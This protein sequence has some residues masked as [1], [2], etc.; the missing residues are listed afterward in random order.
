MNAPPVE[1]LRRLERFQLDSPEAALPFSTRL[2][3][4][5]NWPLPYTHRV[6]AEYKRFAFLAV[7]AGHP[8]SPSEDVDQAWHLHLTYSENYWKVFCPEIL[9]QPLHHQPT[10]GGETERDKFEDWYARTLASYEAFFGASPPADIWPSPAARRMESHDFVRV[11]RK[12]SWVI[13]KPRLQLNPKFAAWFGLGALVLAGS[14]AMLAQ[15]ANPF[16]WRGS[17]FLKFYILLFIASFAVG[18]VLRR[19]LRTP[20]ATEPLA[21]PDLDGY[22]TA[23]LNGGKLL[24]VNT[25]V[26]TLANQKAIKPDAGNR[27]L[28]SLAPKPSFEHALERGVYSAADTPYGKTIAEVRNAV[29]PIVAG[30]AEDLKAQGLVVSDTAARRAILVPLGIA[31]AAIAVG[32]VKIIIGIGRD[33]PVGILTALCIVSLFASLIAFARRPLRSRKGDAVLNRLKERHIGPHRLGKDSA[34]VPAAEFATVVGLFGLTALAGTELDDV[35]RTLQP[36]ASSSGSSCGASSG[37]CGGGGCGGGGCGG[38]G[39]N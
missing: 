8:V 19:N 9:G 33:K 22:A 16:D 17:T 31:L 6:I 35:R 15:G 27:R 20:D 7:A 10:R 30:I 37:S 36:P 23:F 1:L 5:N 3:R 13:P 24:T 4:E 11:N 38:C 25:A 28:T 29:K 34:T 18:L 14:G 32:V 2:A 12:R 39:G 21:V 26:A